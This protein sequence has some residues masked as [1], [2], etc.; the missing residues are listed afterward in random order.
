MHFVVVLLFVFSYAS[1]GSA[2]HVAGHKEDSAH[3]NNEIIKCNHY[4]FHSI[5]FNFQLP[6]FSTAT[7]ELIV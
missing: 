3:G 6:S 2:N 4:F 5:N 7:V 1:F